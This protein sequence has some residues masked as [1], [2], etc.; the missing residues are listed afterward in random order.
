MSADA[1]LYC[2][3]RVSDYRDFERLCSSILAGMNYPEIDPLGG[4]GDKG[5]DA[6]IHADSTGRKIC[7]AYTVRSDWRIK[8]RSDAK[9]VH[10]MG[11]APDVFVFVCTEALCASEKD[12][13]RSIIQEYGWELDLFDIERIRVQLVGPQRHLLAHHPSIFAPPF[14]PQRGGESISESRDTLVI[15]HVPADAA[16]AT[17]LAR[18]LSLA[19]FRTWCNGTAPLAGENVD[20]SVRKLI[21]FRAINY[22]PVIS[23]SSLS[24]GVFIERCTIAAM[25]EGFVLPCGVTTVKTGLPSRLLKVMFADFNESWKTGLFQVIKQLNSLGV[26]PSLDSERGKKIAL[27]DYLPLQLTIPQPEPVIANLFDLQLPEIMYIFD[28]LN[29]LDNQEIKEARKLWAFAVVN[30]HQISAFTH[31]TDNLFQTNSIAR[32][33]K[34]LW[35]DAQDKYSVSLVNLAKQLVWRSLNLSCAFKGLEYCERN[36]LYYFPRT[37][38][39]EWVQKFKH[40]DGRITDVQLTGMRTKGFGD[41]ASQF[42]YQLAPVF[43][44]QGGRQGS[45]SVIVKIYVRVTALDGQL[46]DGKEI[47]RR[48]KIVTKSWWNSQFLARLLGIT[49]AIETSEGHVQIGNGDEAVVMKT[50]PIQWE[51]PVGLDVVALSG[52]ADIGQEIAEYRTKEDD[53]FDEEDA[54]E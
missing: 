25:K 48:R 33:S 52:L 38:L 43:R 23:S 28:F 19:G 2:L 26:N 6:I 17:W 53:D 12:D 18:R 47:G 8:L 24:D 49:Q 46:F 39:R 7:F 5:R 27:R 14:F 4:T 9:R 50:T 41:S 30:D 13:A 54:Q 15:D 40:L 21:E 29:P 32:T 42:Y 45:W 31:P 11:H 34:I 37:S 22:L 36:K 1:I 51:C 3:E 44:P 20:D 16:L 35:R 10:E